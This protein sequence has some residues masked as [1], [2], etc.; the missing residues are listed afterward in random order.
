MAAYL[1]FYSR[2]P[3]PLGDN[4]TVV[5]EAWPVR[6]PGGWVAHPSTNRAGCRA[7]SLWKQTLN[8]SGHCT[9][10]R[11]G[12]LCKWVTDLQQV[13]REVWSTAHDVECVLTD[14]GS[15][16]R[17]LESRWARCPRAVDCKRINSPTGCIPILLQTPINTWCTEFSIFST[18]CLKLAATNSSH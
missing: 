14:T 4:T 7:T 9:D 3:L 1:R 11:S 12:Y 10:T 2:A 8:Q 18:V 6:R 13:V 5:C 16:S 17:P 15:T